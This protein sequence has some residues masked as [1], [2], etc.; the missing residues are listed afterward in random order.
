M[1]DTTQNELNGSN[2]SIDQYF[3]LLYK[4]V[5]SRYLL[6]KG[7]GVEWEIDFQNPGSV[8]GYRH[9]INKNTENTENTENPEN[10]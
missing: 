2:A 1:Q 5:Y 10:A 9:T 6:S 3:N 7:I 8:T 4:D